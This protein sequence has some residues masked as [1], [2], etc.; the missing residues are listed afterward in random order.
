M[1]FKLLLGTILVLTTT[2]VNISLIYVS[3]NDALTYYEDEPN[4]TT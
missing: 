4:G 3:E 1:N 2:V